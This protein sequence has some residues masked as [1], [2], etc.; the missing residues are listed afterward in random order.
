MAHPAP[1]SATLGAGVPGGAGTA[2]HGGLRVL[3]LDTQRGWRGGERQVFWLARELARLGHHGAIAAR[4]AEP[5]A[6]RAAGEGIPVIPCEPLVPVDPLAALALRRRIVRDGYAIVHAHTAHA[7]TLGALATLGT[8]AALVVT[9]R[10]DFAIGGGIGTRWKFARAAAVIAISRKVKEVLEDGGVPAAKIAVIP[11]G[12]DLSRPMRRAAQERL[13]ALGVRAERGPLVA[14]VAA[15]VEH[16]DPLNF[17]RAVA[18]ARRLSRDATFQALLVGD[19]ELMV[20]VRAERAR[21]ALEDT[22]L[23]AGWQNDADEIVAACDVLVL[24]SQEEGLG[25]VLL[26]GMQAGKPIAATMAGGIPDIVADGETGLLAP[27]RDPARLGAALARLCADPALRARLGAAG[28]QRVREFSVTRTAERTA[29]VY[30]RVLAA[31][32]AS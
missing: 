7:V 6:R 28:A 26:D 25:S 17:V 4:P 23:L 13:A 30:R 10:V 5:L 12:A 8:N 16:K 15:L 3:H 14:M 27:I 31:R 19:G 21:L 20:A 22:L 9:R 11:S 18:E 29:D 32:S 1:P 2:E 24:S